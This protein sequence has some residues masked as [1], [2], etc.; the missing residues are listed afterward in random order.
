IVV[1][2]PPRRGVALGFAG[3]AGRIGYICE[4]AVAIVV[5]KITPLTAWMFGGI[6]DVGRD[7]DIEPAVAVVVAERSHHAGILDVETV[8]VT[9]LLEGTVALVDIEQ[10]RGIEPADVNI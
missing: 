7:I 3:D 4:R 9:H 1:I 10:I 8:G 6:E 2:V 5:E